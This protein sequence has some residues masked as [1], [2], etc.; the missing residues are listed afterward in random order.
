M[1]AEGGNHITHWK[2]DPQFSSQVAYL[3]D[4]LNLMESYLEIGPNIDIAPGAMF[5]GFREFQLVDSSYDR[6]RKGLARCQM[7]RTIAP[8]ITENPLMM[9]LTSMD[10]N[11]VQ[12]AVE[13][14]KEVG[15]EMLIFS[16]GSNFNMS[17][18]E[19]GVEHPDWF[20][21]MLEELKGDIID[22]V[23]EAGIDVG[24]YSLLASRK[25][26]N[27][28]DVV[29]PNTGK[30]SDVASPQL[31]P[32]I[33]AIQGV[34]PEVANIKG[35]PM[36]GNSPCLGS[37]WAN[38]YFKSL[39][40]S[41]EILNLN[42]LEHDGSYPGDV[43]ASTKHPGHKGLG[44]SQW[45]QWKIISDF[46]KWCRG[47]GVFLNVPDWYMLVGSNKTGIGYK[48]VN[49]SLPR[50]RQVMLG[51]QNIY[52]GT[53]E[54]TPSMGWTFC[55][56]TPYH[57]VPEYPT[58][59][60]KLEPLS[61]HLSH[62]EAHLVQNLG[63]GVQAC[64]RG[65]R[66]YDTA[67]TKDLVKKYVKWYKEYRDILDSD[68]VHIRRPDGR[69]IDGIL[70]VNPRILVKGLAMFFNPTNE[71]R[72]ENIKVPLYYTG[73]VDK[74]V[75]KEKGVNPCSIELSRD[76]SINLTLEIPANSHTWITF[77]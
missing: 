41:I 59:V 69:N 37:H 19:L 71:L 74:A 65:F 52:D 25:I 43:C 49:W 9:H 62:Y 21:D 24:G 6:Q 11:A 50:D 35:A 64:Y 27:E 33:E 73:I 38:K 46:Y 26:S 10:P 2:I 76:S 34:G 70:H 48:E 20:D 66:L 12:L 30:T 72:K 1:D 44:D 28:D 45:T 47:Q 22:K 77:E 7:Y 15:F 16:F 53:W 13:Q 31:E 5:E 55:P 75:V 68:I 18:L 29:N 56:L 39:K 23:H 40:K 3:S 8:W 42:I 54:K 67:I 32:G 57:S 61:E 63:S 51:R 60:A 17:V 36:F 58:E 14:M 4:S